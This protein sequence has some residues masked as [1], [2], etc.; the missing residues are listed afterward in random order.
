M[1]KKKTGFTLIET[2][3]VIGII[4]LIL[5]ISLPKFTKYQR[6]QKLK[7]AAEILKSHLSEAQ[8]IAL[9]FTAPSLTENQEETINSIF[10]FSSSSYKL[11]KLGYSNSILS[12]PFSQSEQV[13]KN[14]LL[15][16]GII[17]STNFG[18]L[19]GYDPTGR[20]SIPEG[21]TNKGPKS[22]QECV[23]ALTLGNENIYLKIKGLGPAEISYTA[24]AGSLM[25]LNTP[26]TTQ[27][28]FTPPPVSGRATPTAATQSPSPVIT[29]NS[30][31]TQIKIP[32]STPTKTS[33]PIPTPIPTKTTPAPTPVKTPAKLFTGFKNGLYYIGGKLGSGN[34]NG[35]Y[36]VNGRLFSGNYNGKYYVNGRLGSGLYQGILYIE[37]KPAKIT[38]II[39]EVAKPPFSG[40]KNGLYYIG[41]K[42]GSGNYQGLYYENGKP[43]TG[44]KIVGFKSYFWFWRKPIYIRYINGI[45]VK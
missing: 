9:S 2:L 41:G 16:D 29:P 14:I 6:T 12:T 33:A 32:S 45:P 37:G 1:E 7:S 38:T 44:S 22:F 17:L 19:L 3:V 28:T 21:N 4:G 11:S 5:A 15:K 8:K 13:L 35:L 31:P 34:Y 27:T 25:A 24:P 18:N 36:Y 43:F 30:T 10:N 26:I 23:I 20:I 39:R 40:I 42:L